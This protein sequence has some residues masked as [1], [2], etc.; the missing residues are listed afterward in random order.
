MKLMKEFEKTTAEL[1]TVWM[2]NDAN[3]SHLFLAKYE[4]KLGHLK[5]IPEIINR[6]INRSSWFKH[7]IMR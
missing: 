7:K 1:P 4:T 3:L 6:T 2:R 5:Q